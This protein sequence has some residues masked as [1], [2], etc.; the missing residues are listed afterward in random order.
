MPSSQVDSV[1][2]DQTEII[3]DPES[4]AGRVANNSRRAGHSKREIMEEL[5]RQRFPWDE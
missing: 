5:S 1:K 2:E 4:P 3:P